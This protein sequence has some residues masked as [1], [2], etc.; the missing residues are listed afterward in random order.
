MNIKK[1]FLFL[2]LLSLLFLSFGCG[3]DD[4]K[5]N[6]NEVVQTYTIMFNSNGGI[7]VSGSEVQ[8]VTKPSEIVAPTYERDGYI[9]R[10]FDKD[11]STLTTDSIVNVLWEKEVLNG[12]VVSFNSNGGSLIDSQNVEKG[13][14]I[15]KPSNPER[16]GYAFEGWFTESNTEWVFVGYVVSKDM[17]L[18]AK[19]SIITYNIT[20]TLNGGT[21]S[22]NN[23]TTYTVEDE[24]ILEVPTKTG[25]T[26]SWSNS[27]RIE[28]GS[29][30]NKSFEAI[31]TP[32]QYKITYD[33]NGGNA[34]DS[35]EQLV[36]YDSTYT[37]STPT[38]DSYTFLGWYNGSTKVN[39]GTWK[40]TSDIILTAKWIKGEAIVE[41]ID[42]FTYIYYGKYPQ[43]VVSDTSLINNL[44]NLTET[45]SNGYYEYNGNEYAKFSAKPNL[46][47]ST[48]SNGTKV[49]N[50]STYWFK[51]EP[52]KWKILSQVNGE[53]IVMSEYLLDAKQFYNSTSNRTI[54]GQTIYPN[55]YEYSDIRS[56]LNNEFYNK[57]FT[58]T[59]QSNIITKL[60]DNS[61]SST[62]DSSNSYIC[63]DTNDKVWLLS[64]SDATNTSYGFTTNSKREAKVTDYAIANGINYSTD[65]SYLRNGYWWLRSPYSDHSIYAR[66]VNFDGSIYGIYPDYVGDTSGGVRPALSLTIE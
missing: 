57:S 17:T 18:Y 38:R 28:K 5:E 10:G 26:G 59:E 48:F 4:K 16:T 12:C 52:I 36:T 61:L 65:S 63:N 54:D 7:L 66:Y 25:Y 30:G 2:V 1:V 45:N 47:S 11:L 44:N 43:T 34:L 53:L 50:G 35:N 58:E 37:L 15:K 60:V 33:A 24:V 64:Y 40:Y 51:V 13:D 55:N 23:P 14:N 39:N 41:T 27:G 49:V 32:N 8:K 21:N 6:D 56:W 22:S 62:C 42:G 19:W 3:K 29:I 9:F 31:Y 20:Y 46:S